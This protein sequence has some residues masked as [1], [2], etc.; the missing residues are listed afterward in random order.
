MGLFAGLFLM[1]CGGHPHKPSPLQKRVRDAR[2]ASCAETFGNHAIFH[3]SVDGTDVGREVRSDFVQEGENGLQRVFISHLV[4][5]ERM[6]TILFPK[7]VVKTEVTAVESGLLLE[8]DVVQKTQI[9]TNHIHIFH[10]NNRWNRVIYTNGTYSTMG[11]DSRDTL[12]L[13]GQETIGS[14]MYEKLGKLAIGQISAPQTFWFFDPLHNKPFEITASRPKAE[15][16]AIEG[17]DI[18]G[19]WVEVRKKDEEKVVARGF[20]DGDGLLWVEEYPDIHETRRRVTGQFSLP[21]ET[22]ELIVGLRSETYIYD[23]SSAT[24]ATYHL[25]ASPDRL[26]AIS[27]LDEPHN[28]TLTRVSPEKSV[29]VVHAGAPDQGDPPNDR[30]LG[31]SLYIK[32]NDPSIVQAYKYLRSAGKRGELS[33]ERRLN[34]TPVVARVSLIQHPKKFWADPDKV[35]G[36]IMRYVS[37]LLPDKRHTFSMADA[38]TTLERGAGDCTEHSVLF[39]SLMRAHGIPTRLVSGMFLTRGGLW[40]YHMWAAYWDGEMWQSIDPSTMTLRTGALHVALGGGASVFADIR[41]R[42]ADFM[43][44]TFSG[45]SFDL[46]EAANEGELL[47]L[48]RPLQQHQNLGETA[49]FNAV[50]LSDQGDPLGALKL[51]DENISKNTRSLTVRCMRAELFADAGQC[52][53]AL[54]IIDT[55]R[56]ETSASENTT[57]LDKIELNCLLEN[58][59]FDR[60]EKIYKRVDSFISDNGSERTVLRSKVLFAQGK[61]GEAIALV[62]DALKSH[63][64]DAILLSAFSELVSRLEDADEAVLERA[65]KSA[66]KAVRLTAYADPEVLATFSRLLDRADSKNHAVWFLDHALIL[67]PLNARL[68]TLRKEIAPSKQCD[69]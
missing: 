59:S 42:L 7:T 56:Q 5:N 64:D 33:K 69:E 63:S 15:T 51:L 47:F 67:S 13:N 8:A 40:A 28:Q 16:L 37:A 10:E 17:Q 9:N 62:E 65:L 35:A 24:R 50:V 49:L 55:L 12:P 48:A 1:G 34:A 60:A 30:D 14:L 29:L 18:D 58:K 32:P 22:S 41:E 26:D 68:R 21:S 53:S 43:W 52:Q 38:V 61:E 27:L 66:W 2:S 3:I 45:V 19:V 25:N 23:P 11:S 36:V 4:T 46:V 20:F 31:S 54:D 57:L 6:G 44:R 39:A